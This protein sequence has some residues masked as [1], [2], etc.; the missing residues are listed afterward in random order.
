MAVISLH[1]RSSPVRVV[2][3]DCH[4]LIG[5]ALASRIDREPDMEVV[6]L[7]EDCEAA[8]V[9]CREQRAQTLLAD[10]CLRGGG[11]CSELPA[12]VCREQ[13][14]RLIFLAGEIRPDHVR[15][16]IESST[17]GYVS[18]LQPFSVLREAILSVLQGARYFCSKV[19]VE[20]GIAAKCPNVRA[21]SMTRST[22]L[23]PRQREVL[24]YIA[25]GLAGKEIAKAMG[26]C[27][28]KPW[29]HTKLRSWRGGVLTTAWG[30]LGTPTVQ[31]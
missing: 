2:V 1:T 7:C 3:A 4:C 11:L 21:A 30:L 10:C 25:R 6:G 18:K 5:E 31:V 23:T 15:R 19:R 12:Q 13:E 26:G 27:G 22:L 24:V 17:S 9:I 8:L 28:R 14:P 16:A 29:M 20:T